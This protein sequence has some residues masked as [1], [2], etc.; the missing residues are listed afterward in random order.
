MTTAILLTASLLFCPGQDALAKTGDIEFDETG[1]Y[2][3]SRSESPES[4]E[5][6]A[7]QDALRKVLARQVD[8]S[9][10]YD[11][12]QVQINQT[13]KQF[14][15]SYLTTFSGGVADYS[16]VGEPEITPQPGR[17]FKYM[18][19]VKGTLRFKGA[20][21]PRFDIRFDPKG[22][23]DGKLGLSQP[24]FY[25]GDKVQVSFWST[26]DCFVQLIDVDAENS[27][28]LL[29]PNLQIPSPKELKAGELFRY[30]PD[31]AEGA[32]MSVIAALPPEKDETVEFLHIILTKDASLFSTAE[33]KESSLGGYK[34]LTLGDRSLIAKRL[35]KLDRSK[36]TQHVLPY[37]IL[38][39]P[40]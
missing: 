26:E 35:G 4:A 13:Y 2:V 14:L 9:S 5:K 18:V 1:E 17:T 37:R 40:Q 12:S 8:I 28:S 34:L 16:V 10:V 25:D 20:P 38:R 27:A 23:S 36:W 11:D 30:P 33:A 7:E 19:R 31:M 21:D 39:R 15:A 6:K 22:E 3:A 24:Q 29:Y 32:S